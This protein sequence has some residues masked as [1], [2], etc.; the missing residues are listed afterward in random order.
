MNEYGPRLGPGVNHDTRPR[1]QLIAIPDT[2]DDG[3][4][5]GPVPSD[6]GRPR[7]C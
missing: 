2:G 6:G 5:P 1:P 7:S 3:E 4:P